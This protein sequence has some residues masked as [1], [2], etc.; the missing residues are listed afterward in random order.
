VRAIIIADE[1]KH[2]AS[3]EEELNRLSGLGEDVFLSQARLK[4]HSPLFIFI[5]VTAERCI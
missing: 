3:L 5:S 1:F 2:E 4:L